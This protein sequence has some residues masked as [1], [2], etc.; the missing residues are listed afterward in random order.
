MDA[1]I[2]AYYSR[3]Y[4]LSDDGVDHKEDGK[5]DRPA[6]LAYNKIIRRHRDEYGADSDQGQGIKHRGERRYKR[7][8]IDSDYN[9]A[10]EDLREGDER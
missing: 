2:F 10:K 3:L 8:L 5:S 7:G 4:D 1:E 9:E 6:P